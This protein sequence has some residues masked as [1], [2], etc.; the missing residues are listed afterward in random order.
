MKL[1]IQDGKISLLAETG[2]E[3][4]ACA[5]LAAFDGNVYD[6]RVQ[7]GEQLILLHLGER[8]DL[9]PLNITRGVG[10]PFTA[11]S[12]LAD[13]PFELDDELYGS[14][15]GFWQ[16]LKFASE[17][18]RRRVGLLSGPRAKQTGSSEASNTIAFEYRGQ[19]YVR[20]TWAHWK[21]MERA[22]EA[23]FTQNHAAREALLATGNR[24]LT[25]RVPKDSR[26]I[27]G[28]IMAEI[29]MRVRSRLR[30]GVQRSRR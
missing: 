7:P 3:R 26:T 23:K 20:G 8:E 5:G 14:V 24:P 28:V 29:W 30:S 18:D 21:L 6:L 4:D 16:S 15:E 13:T 25:H 12:N 10:F 1:T 17:E 22:C 2:E 9:K 11:I 27:P 19:T